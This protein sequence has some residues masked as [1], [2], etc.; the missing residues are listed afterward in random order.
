MRRE[1]EGERIREVT[2]KDTG[3]WAIVS[4]SLI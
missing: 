1:G 2:E 3:K 4:Y